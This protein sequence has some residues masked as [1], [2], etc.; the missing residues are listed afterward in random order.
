MHAFARGWGG[1]IGGEEKMEDDATEPG[2]A[3][4]GKVWSL[5]GETAE[6]GAEE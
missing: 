6:L 1:V 3:R 5:Y 2:N 4:P